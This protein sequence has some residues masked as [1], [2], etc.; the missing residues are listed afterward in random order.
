MDKQGGAH[1]LSQQRDCGIWISR[2]HSGSVALHA[3]YNGC[4]V[5]EQN[6]ENV[7]RIMV[8]MKYNPGNWTIPQMKVLRCPKRR[9]E[10]AVE[11]A[12]SNETISVF[13]QEPL[14]F[15]NAEETGV[16]G[17]GSP[18]PLDKEWARIVVVLCILAAL[19]IGICV[20]KRRCMRMQDAVRRLSPGKFSETALNEDDA[21]RPLQEFAEQKRIEREKNPEVKRVKNKYKLKAP[22]YPSPGNILHTG[23]Q[24][25]RSPAPGV[26]PLLPSQ[27]FERRT[28][29][30]EEGSS[31]FAVKATDNM[32]PCGRQLE[33]TLINVNHLTD[34]QLSVKEKTFRSATNNER[35]V[36]G[37]IICKG[38]R[39]RTR[40]NDRSCA[41]SEVSVVM[42]DLHNVSSRSDVMTVQKRMQD[43]V[44]R[45]SPGKF[46]ETALN[47]D[48]ALRPLQEFAEQKRIVRKKKRVKNKNKY[49]LKAPAY[50]SP[51]N[52]L[53]TGRQL[54]RSPAPGVLPLLPSQQ[55]ERRTDEDE[56]GSSSFAVKATD[57]MVPCGRQL[58]RTLINVNLLTDIQVNVKEK[59]FRSA[60]NNERD[61]N[62]SIICKGE[63]RRTRR[64]DRSC[65]ASEVSVVMADLHNVSSRSDVM[66]VQKRSQI[67]GEK[68]TFK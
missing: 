18:G 19:L 47:E 32:V 60:K 26:L 38:E 62:G 8:K 21:L 41:A 13:P 29:E 10:R 7:M 66:T 67:C 33:R 57:N 52:I 34:V 63:R 68:G 55:F 37:S 36:N 44:R 23:R 1:V 51:G 45:L 30:D 12:A 14:Y 4:Y 65:A 25:P 6:D 22:A 15:P 5:Y 53:H 64:N 28:D 31:S 56:E 43:A 54:P 59:T 20:I 17:Q 46:S 9:E 40:R 49:K 58:E 50:P 2:R 3:L 11:E 61:V 16:P 24:L 27:Q 48:D 35:D 42:A 39:R